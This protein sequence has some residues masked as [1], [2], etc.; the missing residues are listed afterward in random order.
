M[1]T[2]IL[3]LQIKGYWFFSKYICDMTRHDSFGL[4]STSVSEERKCK[5]VKIDDMVIF[6]CQW[7]YNIF[8]L[9]DL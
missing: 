9:V 5:D 4:G 7:L 8:W 1:Y 3:F 2:H 6:L